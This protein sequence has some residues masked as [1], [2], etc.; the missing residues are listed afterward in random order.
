[1]FSPIFLVRILSPEAFGQYREFITYAMLVSGLAAFSITQNLLYFIPRHPENTQRYVGHT[2]WLTFATSILA[3]VTLWVFG[4][5]IRSNTSF[6][7]LLP[8]GAYVLLY[9]NLTFM[10]AYWIATQQP[11]FVF[12][13]STIRTAAR[14]GA[15]VLTAY[16]TRSVE[17]I[18]H[19]LILVEFARVVIVLLLSRQLGLL[20][21]KIDG[22]M[23]RQQRSFIVPAGMASSLN[24]LHLYLGPIVISV[25]LG[26]TALAVYAVASYKAPVVRII[27][28][29]VSD[30]IFPDMVR[31]AASEQHDR[32]RL[33]KRG[34]IAYSFLIVPIFFVLFW[35]A[36]VLIPFVFTDKY[37][38]AVPIF[39]IL[40]LVMPIEAIEM[41]SPLRAVN[42]TRHLLAGNLLLVVANL[43][44]IV[45]FFR[46]FKEVAILGAAIGVV[47]G[48]IV[49]HIYMGW[50]IT[51][52][53]GV[54]IGNLLKWRS[55]AAIYICTAT[56]GLTLLAGEFLL[57][58]AY[59]RLPVFTLLY[60]GA[61]FGMLRLFRLEEV[62]TIVAA[63]HQRLRHRRR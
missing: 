59:F 8:L 24:Q 12:Y 3:C 37:V 47:A 38:G 23:L 9:S 54:S 33:W 62:E 10:E 43:L 27:R 13:F 29:A 50:Q 51:R 21:F 32:L 30:A 18:L 15:V 26:V 57:L 45:I 49:Q 53:Y 31:Q 40:L 39:R 41:N 1:M 7:F 2:N 5:Q 35:Y 28:G 36:D 25:Q 19:A 48:Y 52:V 42:Q 56:S 22:E 44:C 58:P 60:F 20:T 6:D 63:L 14:L 55:Q 17:A 61:Y 34:N 11:K 46:Y 4:E 16:Q